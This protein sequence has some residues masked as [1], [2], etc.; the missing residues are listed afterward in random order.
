MAGE[1]DVTRVL[2]ELADAVVVIDAHSAIRYANAAAARLLRVDELVGRSLLDFVPDEYK[3]QHTA[4]VSRYFATGSG[5]VVGGHPVRV[6]ALRGD[7]S[8][9]EVALTLAATTAT[10]G[11]RLVAGSLRDVTAVR[12][13]E[14]QA[15]V[16]SYLRASMDVA[17]QLQQADS[18][19]KALPVVLP[20]LCERLDWDL[21]AL[22]LVEGTHLRAVDV[23]HGTTP[24]AV[25]FV[26]M[27]RQVGFGRGTG[28]PGSV[29][30]LGHP[31]HI[32][33]LDT[34]D[35][36]PRRDAA[37]RAGLMSTLAFPLVG[38]EGV[39]GVVELWSAQQ[40]AADPEEIEVVAAIGKQLGQFLERMDAEDELR[41]S[42]EAARALAETLQRSLLPP[43]LPEL[44]GFDLASRYLAGGAG[45]EVGGDFFDV[46]AV[47]PTTWVIVIGDV[48]GKGAAAA[49]VTA[50]ARYT[51]R[52]AA[53]HAEGPVGIAEALHEA[54]QR[55]DDPTTP[56]VTAAVIVLCLD[57]EAPRLRVCCA[58]HPLPLLRSDDGSV[59]EVGRPGDI[60]GALPEPVTLSDVAVTLA[61]GDAV[62]LYT[63]G[64]TEARDEEGTE[65]G[66][67]G[68]RQILAATGGQSADATAGRIVDALLAHRGSGN[69][70]DVAVLAVRYVG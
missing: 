22:W 14:R 9:V 61:P 39:L 68:L 57:P 58:G 30:A 67:G 31:L 53:L 24:G 60:L 62:V 12:E 26:E 44:P 2:G 3:P 32:D 63:D 8:R 48:C 6:P 55:A 69:R 5:A 15:A 51:V 66:V 23:W 35:S 38:S 40:R 28:L 70:D 45:L 16:A 34:V 41:R 36:F 17:T 65:F 20:T 1:V 4:G 10:D 52:A 11:E 64:V 43:H 42:E 21:A 47:D 25:D 49:T 37:R 29:W 13:L 33:S 54:L 7:G 18:R 59:R 46:F 19:D 27:T 50:L 56:F